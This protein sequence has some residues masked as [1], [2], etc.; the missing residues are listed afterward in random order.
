V[1]AATYGWLP[2]INTMDIAHAA[3]NIRFAWVSDTHLYP[4]SVNT[5]F[6]DKAER[7]F[8]EIEAMKPDFMIFG[9]D[10]AQVG[11]PEELELGAQLLQAVNVPK[12]FIPG[13]H[14]WYLDMGKLWEKKFGGSPWSKDIKGVHFVGLNTIGQ[15]PDF[16]SAKGM[17]PRERMGH[18]EPLDGSVAGPWSGLGQ[19]QLKWLESDLR[20][21]KKNTPIVLFSHN[22]LYEYY[23]P[24]N[25]WVRDWREVHEIVRPYS[26][27]TNVHGHT[28]QVLYNEIGGMRSIWYVWQLSWPL[29]HTHPEGVPKDDSPLKS[30]LIPGDPFDGCWVG[31]LMNFQVKG[32]K[33]SIRCGIETCLPLLLLILVLVTILAS[34]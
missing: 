11:M 18:I 4:K 14:D 24:W 1:G 12:Y 6:V 30:E 17:T 3:S 16:W 13:E 22:P 15:A 5:R 8:K 34:L 19:E 27:V 20:K 25:F 7:A 26:N 29:A 32:L 23:P 2:L 9:G 28:H 31:L 21:V 10:L 33:M